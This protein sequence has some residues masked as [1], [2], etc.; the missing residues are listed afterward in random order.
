VWKWLLT[1]SCPSVCPSS[2]SNSAP[3]GRIFIKFDFWVFIGN[4]LE[5]SSTLVIKWQWKIADFPLSRFWH[6]GDDTFYLMFRWSCIVVYLCSKNQR[7][8]LFVFDLLWINGLYM[9]RALLTHLQEALHKQQLV[10]CVRIMS[11]FCYQD[12]SSLKMSK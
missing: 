8:A 2:T 11:V 10:F 12:W 5:S 3:T 4:R 1:L 6:K 9:F 7:D